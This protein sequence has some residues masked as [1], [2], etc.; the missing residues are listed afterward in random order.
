VNRIDDIVARFRKEGWL[1]QKTKENFWALRPQGSFNYK[2]FLL[3]YNPFTSKFQIVKPPNPDRHYDIAVKILEASDRPQVKK[4][5]RS[6]KVSYDLSIIKVPSMFPVKIGNLWINLA[7]IRTLK[8]IPPSDDDMG[9]TVIIRWD[10]GEED[11]LESE[12]AEKFLAEWEK[13]CQLIIQ[14]LSLV[15]TA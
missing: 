5:D 8:V 13:T 1:V 10:S 4:N 6:S 9:L 3:T 7:L 2:V 14:K 15:E 12:Q 11:E